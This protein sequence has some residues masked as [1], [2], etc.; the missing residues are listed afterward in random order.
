MGYLFFENL[1]S[2]NNVEFQAAIKMAIHEKEIPV[3]DFID[4]F[5]ISKGTISRWMRGKSLPHKMA[6][7]SIISW[8]IKRIKD[9][10]K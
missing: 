8:I 10:K 1:N 7:S 2:D 9:D 4:Q 6:R 3:G 5:D